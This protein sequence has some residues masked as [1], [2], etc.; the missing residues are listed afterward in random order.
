LFKIANELDVQLEEWDR[1]EVLF[2]IANELDVQLEEWDI[3]RVHRFGRKPKPLINFGSQTPKP[4][5]IIARFVS[6]KKT[7]KISICKDQTKKQQ[8][9][10]WYLHH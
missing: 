6:Y 5:P 4:R 3:Q 7:L 8:I 10:T 9:F 2:K 1:E